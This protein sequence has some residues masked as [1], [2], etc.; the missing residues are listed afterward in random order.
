VALG[1]LLNDPIENKYRGLGDDAAIWHYLKGLAAE[2]QADGGDDPTRGSRTREE[3]A[4]GPM[5]S[6]NKLPVVLISYSD[7][8]QFS[9]VP[10]SFDFGDWQIVG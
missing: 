4:G 7:V 8:V 9:F 10:K 2:A 5:S 3:C 6:N 1:D